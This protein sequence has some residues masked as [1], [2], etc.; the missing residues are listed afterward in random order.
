MP[1]T[2][3]SSGTR[4][5]SAARRPSAAQGPRRLGGRARLL[6]EPEE[7]AIADPDLTERSGWPCRCGPDGP[8][9]W[10]NVGLAGLLKLGGVERGVGVEPLGADLGAESRSLGDL[11]HAVNERRKLDFDLWGIEANSRPLW[12]RASAGP[13]VSRRPDLRGRARFSGGSHVWALGRQEPRG[14]QAA[15]WFPDEAG[16][17]HS[18][19]EAGSDETVTARVRF[20]AEVGWW[21]ART[22]GVEAP[23]EGPLELELQ[24]AN[25]DAF[26]GWVLS[27]GPDA[28]VLAPEELRAQVLA[29]I[30]AA[31]ESAG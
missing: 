14:L 9:G 15:T 16:D 10:G 17:E 23:E 18:A 22:L 12:N 24:V 3:C 7:Y 29:R 13:L 27:F 5:F 6:V 20:D 11:F 8:A 21:A 1:S 31:L 28:E 26:I 25:R 4:K 19:W 30:Q 2:A